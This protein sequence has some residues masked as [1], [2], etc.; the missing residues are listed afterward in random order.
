[1]IQVILQGGLGN[2]MFE[3][4]TVYALARK[5]ETPFALNLSYMDVFAQKQWCRP[6]ELS[7]FAL[8]SKACFTHKHRFAVRILGRLRLFC[9]KHH[10]T[11]C[12][13]YY[14]DVADKSLMKTKS[15]ILFD[16]C[17]D[18]HTFDAYREDLL[19]EFDFAA[20]PNTQNQ[21]L[22][23]EIKKTNSVSVHIRRGDY[24]NETNKQMFFTPS[25]EWYKRAMEMIEKYVNAPHYYFFSDDIAWVREHFADIPN[26]TLVNINHGKDAYNDMRL[27]SA[28]RHNIIANSTFSWWGA[29]L[30]TNPDK[31][32]IAPARYYNNPADISS[33]VEKMIP[34]EWIVLE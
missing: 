24:L 6:Y 13:S 12:G 21:A 15:A 14:F 20:Q 31:I 17:A 19:K 26:A 18:Y 30:N 16:Y 7:A 3:Y 8:H 9:R 4:A 34:K 23:D 10:R 11:H 25:V 1:M 5:Q 28:C 27:M 2:Q 32:V 33:Y 29:W 22:L